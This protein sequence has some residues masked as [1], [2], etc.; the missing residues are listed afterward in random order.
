[1]EINN[2]YIVMVYEK[3][4]EINC[5]MVILLGKEKFCKGIDEYFECYDG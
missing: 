4:V 3:G 5:M 1:M 2:F